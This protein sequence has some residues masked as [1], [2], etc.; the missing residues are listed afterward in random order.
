MIVQEQEAIQVLLVQDQVHIQEAEAEAEIDITE[1]TVVEE[2][3]MI[4]IVAD[5]EAHHIANQDH[6]VEI[7]VEAE[8]EVVMQRVEVDQR[9]IQEVEV[10]AILKGTKDQDHDQ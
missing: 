9:K 4:N 1:E 7:E 10:E 8:A 5:V 2:V 3:D 6:Q